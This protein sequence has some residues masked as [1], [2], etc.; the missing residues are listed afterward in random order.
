M[1]RPALG[2]HCSTGIVLL[3]IILLHVIIRDANE[4]KREKDLNFSKAQQSS[5]RQVRTQ[6]YVILSSKTTL[7]NS[8][9]LA[10]D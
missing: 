7:S 10:V 9:D 1:P 3:S 6:N 5:H 8:F 2:F 4:K